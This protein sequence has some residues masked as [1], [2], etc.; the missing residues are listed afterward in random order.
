MDMSQSI[1]PRSDQLNADDLIAGPITVKITA[2]TSGTAEQP[3]NVEIEE[4]PGR[5]FKPSKSMRRVLVAA[6][7]RDSGAYIGQQLTLYRDPDVTFG[8]EKVGGIR[9]S[10]MTGITAPLTVPLT[11]T[12][13]KRRQFTVQ[14]LT[15][16]AAPTLD[17][18]AAADSED[19]LK[20]MWPAADDTVRAAI[21]Q[22]VDQIRGGDAA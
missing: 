4:Y 9:I 13:G 21:R 5:S 10:H 8:R 18:V 17:D 2:V 19:A 14:P 16:T 12:R 11:V 6:W 15:L 22:R 3:V 7:G 20:A 1:E